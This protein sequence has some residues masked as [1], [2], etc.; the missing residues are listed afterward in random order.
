MPGKRVYA[1]LQAAELELQGQQRQFD[2]LSS[3]GKQLLQ[4]SRAL[5]GFDRQPLSQ[6]LVSLTAKWTKCQA[7]R[8]IHSI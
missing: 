3:R 6:Q 4:E 7:V 2:Y 5:P 1:V 8:V